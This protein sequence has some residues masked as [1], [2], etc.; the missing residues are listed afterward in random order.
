MKIPVLGAIVL[1]A[2]ALSIPAQACETDAVR[3]VQQ[4]GESYDP[5]QLTAQLVRLTVEAPRFGESCAALSATIRPRDG[6]SRIGLRRLG[7]ALAVRPVGSAAVARANASQIEIAPAA[8]QALAR[9]G[10]ITLD[11]FQIDAGQFLPVGDYVAELEWVLDGHEPQPIN[12]RVRIEPSVRLAGD[13]VRRLSLGDVSDGGDA[14]S[15][16]FYATNASLRVTARSRNS[17]YLQHENGP[18]YGAIAYEAYLSDRKLD[19]SRQAVIDL[20]FQTRELSSQ[21]LH[22]RVRPQTGRYAGT[23]R[24]ILTLDFVAY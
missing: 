8:R 3:T 11:L 12:V 1:A 2:I 23:Y 21:E 4:G 20:G 16:F 9:E 15:R 10:R 5:A 14:R 19:L 13:H 17:G 7:E 6:A 22:V 18:A 24:D